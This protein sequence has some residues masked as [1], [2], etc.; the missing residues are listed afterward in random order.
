MGVQEGLAGRVT[1]DREPGGLE[2]RRQGVAHR[3]VVVDD[4]NGV[5]NLAYPVYTHTH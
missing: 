1:F 3:V 4:V 2:Q 5:L